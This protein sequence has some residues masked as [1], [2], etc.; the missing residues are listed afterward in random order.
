MA[1]LLGLALAWFK[2]QVF[3]PIQIGGVILF[4]LG[5]VAILAPITVGVEKELLNQRNRN[6][7]NR[8]TKSEN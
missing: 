2:G 4:I 1:V 7:N 3:G 6:R 5:M 8:D